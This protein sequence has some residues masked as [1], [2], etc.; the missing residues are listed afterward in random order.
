MR[1]TSAQRRAVF[2]KVRRRVLR[3]SGG[4]CA[5]SL[6]L[7]GWFLA[8][9]AGLARGDEIAP[10]PEP[11]AIRVL[12]MEANRTV[13]A[14]DGRAGGETVVGPGSGGL[15]VDRRPVGKVWRI[16]GSGIVAVNQM[17]FRG[18]L[19]FRRISNGMQV[20]NEVELEDYVSGILGREIY[21]DWHPETLKAQA[22]VARSYALHQRAEARGQAFH[23]EA[24]TGSQ[25]YGGVAAETRS[26]RAAVAATRGEYL[27]YERKPIL[28]V[29]HSASGGQTASS[30]EVWGRVMPYLVSL[31]VEDEQDSP[32]T[33]WRASIS[34]T[35]LGRALDSLGIRIGSP[36][37]VQVVDRSRSGRALRVRIRGDKGQHILE[38][39]ALRVALGESVIRSTLFEIR[40]AQDAVVF[41]GSGH[42]HGVGMSQWGAQAMAQR[43]STYRE[44]VQAFYPGTS[45]VGG[46]A[47]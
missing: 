13:R 9:G 28:A 30:E 17:R 16:G 44:I 18:K 40:P 11:V 7:I 43:G 22:V 25:V 39:R 31:E 27:T 29:Y 36:R 37:E 10:T 3:R 47:R 4:R 6:T 46:A 42:G 19:E 24:G 14:R 26:I 5:A 2:G 45:L 20:I 32:D 35:K 34:K 41:V 12:L 21:P 1:R 33:Y 8:I 23:L 38:A 15:L